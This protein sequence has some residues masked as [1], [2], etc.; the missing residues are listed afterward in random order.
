MGSKRLNS[1]A[2]GNKRE[3]EV[4]SDLSKRFN[5]EFLRTLSSGASATRRHDCNNKDV[6]FIKNNTGDIICPD[7]FKFVIESKHYKD[8]DFFTLFNDKNLLTDWWRQSYKDSKRVGKHSLVFF[9]FNYKKK[10]AM[11]SIDFKSDVAKFK[12]VIINNEFIVITQD[13]LF[14]LPNG[15]FFPN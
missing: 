13:D 11:L 14:S 3:W 12:N 2:K 7:G 4:C 10:M 9:K 5:K 1:N 15:F 8:F 6:E